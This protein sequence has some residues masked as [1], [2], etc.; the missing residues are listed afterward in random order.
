[1]TEQ[2]PQP[3][4][5]CGLDGRLGISSSPDYCPVH[6]KTWVVVSPEETSQQPQDETMTAIERDRFFGGVFPTRWLSGSRGKCYRWENSRVYEQATAEYVTH[7]E[8]A[9]REA[10]T[11]RDDARRMCVAHDHQASLN[12]GVDRHDAL[13]QPKAGE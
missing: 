7:L 4:C 12:R 1:M 6:E 9:L 3:K 11:Q 13:Q 2:T 10:E 8:G 5:T